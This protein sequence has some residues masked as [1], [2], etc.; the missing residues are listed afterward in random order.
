MRVLLFQFTEPQNKVDETITDL[1]GHSE[2]S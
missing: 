2:V 1:S